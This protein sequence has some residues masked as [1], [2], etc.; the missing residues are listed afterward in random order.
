M[1][2]RDHGGLLHRGMAHQRVL[3]RHRADPFAARLDQVLRAVGER[4]VSLRVDRHHVARLE[5][6]VLRPA[7][8]A[9]LHVGIGGRDPGT[10]HLQLALRLSVPRR[11]VARVVDGADLHER[12]GQSLLRADAHLLVVRQAAHL[13]LEKADRAERRH[14][15][16]PP[17]VDEP[18]AVL[19]ETADERLGGGGSADDH[20]Q[21]GLQLPAAGVLL[22]RVEDAH[23]D[24]GNAR[25]E[26]DALALEE[27][28]QALRI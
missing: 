1:W 2:D 22:Q 7:I 14:L 26:R 11:L 4:Q 5:P 8:L 18:Q 25:P 6:A 12:R 17:G 10:A 13:L 21:S 28:E 27:I 15:R 23:P 19:V 16:H 3:Q 24:G 20:A 9:T